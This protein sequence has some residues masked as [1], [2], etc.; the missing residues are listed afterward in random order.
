MTSEGSPESVEPREAARRLLE[1][2][3]DERVSDALLMLRQLADEPKTERPRRRFRTVGVF[4]GERD[5]GKRSKAI[6]RDE[7]GGGSSKTA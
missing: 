6:V 2:V 1:A 4:D 7:F 5:L 3:P